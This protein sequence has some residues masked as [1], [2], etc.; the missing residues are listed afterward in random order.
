MYLDSKVTIWKREFFDDV[1]TKEQILQSLKDGEVLSDEEEF[2]YESIEYL[3]PEENNGNSTVELY[4]KD[5]R[6]SWENGKR[7]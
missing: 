4:H 5:G 6:I 1:F 3:H 2:L 7:H